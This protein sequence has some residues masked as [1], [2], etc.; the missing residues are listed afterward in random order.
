MK[1]ALV[2]A[3]TIKNE[4]LSVGC[5]GLKTPQ[6]ENLG[7]QYIASIAK[8]AECDVRLYLN[9]GNY[10]EL[11]KEILSYNPDLLAISSMTY[12]FPDALQLANDVKKT[13]KEIITVFGGPHSSGD[14][15]IVK[16][17]VVDY[18][19][20][21]EGE[22]TFRVLLDR[23]CNDEDTSDVKGIAYTS[24]KEVVINPVRERIKNLD[25][26]PL[27]V[28]DKEF[29]ANQK[30]YALEVIPSSDL[31]MALVIYSRGCPYNCYFCASPFMWNRKIIYRS[32]DNTVDEIESLVNHY[33]SNFIG[34]ADLNFSTNKSKVKELC[35]EIQRRELDVTWWC[36]STI[37]IDEELLRT[38]KEAG[39]GKVSYGVESFDEDF[40]KSMN[41]REDPLKAKEVIA[42]TGDIGIL[43]HTFLMIDPRTAT[44]ETFQTYLSE[45][46]EITPDSVRIS[47]L[48]PFPGT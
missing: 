34:F 17:N 6:L 38:M 15:S 21:G 31:R 32:P 22:E 12:Q 24:N 47:F 3:G 48:T 33:N 4:A 26:L 18:V 5:V 19:I 30:A 41:K 10:S 40:L 46:K 35:D 20:I 8:S 43:T 44:K 14:P 36:E 1:V 2:D 45:L 42:L 27:P 23:L 29:I 16:E 7:I 9:Q 11:L 39:F 28:R 13:N 37:D 25:A